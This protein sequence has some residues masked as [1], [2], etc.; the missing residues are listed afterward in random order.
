MTDRLVVQKESRYLTLL[1]EIIRWIDSTLAS[2]ARDRRPVRSFGFRRLPRYFSEAMLATAGVVLVE[3]V[4]TPPLSALGLNEF[5]TFEM[6]DPA[7]IT[8][9][10]TYFLQAKYGDAESLHFHELIHVIQWRILGPERFLLLYAKGLARHGYAE[11]PLEKMA[12]V[13]QTRFDVE[14]SSYAVEAEVV[15]QTLAFA[16]LGTTLRHW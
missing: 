12:Y 16:K 8:Y 1:P 6:Q 11:A 4:P 13:H 2:Y 5:T 10:D 3:N 14:Q 9:R 15:Q 7:G